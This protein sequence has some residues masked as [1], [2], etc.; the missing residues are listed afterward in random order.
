MHVLCHICTSPSSGFSVDSSWWAGGPHAGTQTHPIEDHDVWHSKS[1]RKDPLSLK[2]RHHP[3][4]NSVYINTVTHII[5]T[6]FVIMFHCIV[7][8]ILH[9]LLTDIWLFFVFNRCSS[10]WKRE[11][12]KRR[13][14]LCRK[15]WALLQQEPICDSNESLA[16]RI[17]AYGS[18][19]SQR[20]TWVFV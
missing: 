8:S 4:F 16:E 2:Y 10:T 15:K 11:P 17:T 3:W 20:G 12:T 7:M 14:S 6:D 1:E 5:L 13:S 18:W 9:F 19:D